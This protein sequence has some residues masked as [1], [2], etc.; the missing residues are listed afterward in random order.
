MDECIGK[1][2]SSA[3]LVMMRATARISSSMEPVMVI[4]RSCTPGTIAS[5][6]SQVMRT[7]PSRHNFSRQL[8][9]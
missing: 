9:R 5:C 3:I 6:R 2:G 4:T 8:T 7:A 1:L